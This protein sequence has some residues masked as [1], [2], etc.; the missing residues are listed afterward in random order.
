MINRIDDSRIAW[1][2]LR[3]QKAEATSGRAKGVALLSIYIMAYPIDTRFPVWKAGGTV[4]QERGEGEEGWAAGV[5]GYSTYLF[6]TKLPD[7]DGISKLAHSRAI[8]LRLLF[9]SFWC[10]QRRWRRERRWERGA[11]LKHNGARFSVLSLRT[12][13]F[14]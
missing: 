12:I 5:T 9:P 8:L 13:P 4:E 2:C 10:R 7:T 1:I 14:I 6:R 3:N 11:S